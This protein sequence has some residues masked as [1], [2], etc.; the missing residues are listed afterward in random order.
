[1]WPL[2]SLILPTLTSHHSQRGHSQVSYYLPLHLTTISGPLSSLILATLTSHHSLILPTLTSHYS[3]CG[4][5][6]VPYYP[7]LHLN[8]VWPQSSLI[9]PTLTSQ[10]SM[11]T[12]KS[13]TTH[14]YISTQ[15]GHSQVSYY[16]FW[17]HTSPQ[18][19]WP[20]SSLILPIL[21]AHLTTVSVVTVKSHTTHSDSTPHHSQCGQSLKLPILTAHLTT[22]SVRT[23][24]SLKDRPQ[25]RT[26]WT[27]PSP[28]PQ[29][30]APFTSSITWLRHQ[31]DWPAILQWN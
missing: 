4:H 5:S 18:S 19:V 31:P 1:M 28:T 7:P 30:S 20:L 14:P 17:Q 13:H 15:Y 3:Q 23:V 2:S 16:P 27:L 9:L 12:V 10:H 24:S 11:A 21:T 8:T 22:V 6:Q 25:Q 29:P 26:L